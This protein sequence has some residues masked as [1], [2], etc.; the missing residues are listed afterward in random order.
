MNNGQGQWSELLKS[1][2]LLHLGWIMAGSIVLGT[3]GGYWI[4][5]KLGRELTFTVVGFVLG[6]L[7]GGWSCYRL[8]WREMKKEFD[9]SADRRDNTHDK[10]KA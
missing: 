8:L 2:R 5:R 9:A 3:L 10:D 7:S 6:L 4:D 1:L